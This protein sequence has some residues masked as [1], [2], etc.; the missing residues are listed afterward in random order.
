MANDI[1]KMI[2]KCLDISSLSGLQILVGKLFGHADLLGLKVTSTTKL[3][4]VTM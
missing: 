1:L 3:F 2:E 4:F